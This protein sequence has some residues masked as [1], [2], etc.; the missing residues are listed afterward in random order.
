MTFTGVT[1]DIIAE[2]GDGTEPSEASA[3]AICREVNRSELE[4]KLQR[5][6]ETACRHFI[7]ALSMQ[8]NVERGRGLVEE[9]GSVILS[10]P[11]VKR[12]KY[13]EEAGSDDLITLIRERE[14]SSKRN[15]R[16]KTKQ[17]SSSSG[18]KSLKELTEIAGQVA[19]LNNEITILTSAMNSSTE[20]LPVKLSVD[21]RK[22]ALTTI[23]NNL[24][25]K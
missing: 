20:K 17:D 25:E 12:R 24:R 8:G 14:I 6:C 19:T 5:E 15:S 11:D 1:R 22:T 21:K 4:L 10:V 13:Y 16:Q 18:I 23:I 2:A 3:A 9:L 7:R